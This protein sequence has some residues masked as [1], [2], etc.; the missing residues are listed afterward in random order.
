MRVPILMYHSIDSF[1]KGTPMRGLHVPKYKF[2]IQM[3]ILK[4]LGFQGLSLTQL[5]PYLNG[6]RKGKV[7]GI[8]FDDGYKNN[9]GSA[10]PTLSKLNFS[11]T[12][13]IVSNKIGS[14]NSWDLEK[15][16]PEMALMN[17]REIKTWLDCGMEIGSHT[18]SHKSLKTLDKKDYMIE[19]RNSKR[20]LEQKFNCPIY[21]FCY[22]YGHF[23]EEIVR[24]VSKSNYLSATTV[25]RGIADFSSDKF[26]L[27]R[28]PIW[29]STNIFSFL[30]KFFT[31]YENKK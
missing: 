14:I 19:I 12:C 5:L 3:K 29:R 21:H 11:A 4:I 9:F 25:E 17:S 31:N 2:S 27:P 28:V 1:P 24:Y 8:T 16:L 26:K 30:I 18:C 20:E 7:F 22:P 13:Y 23:T 15:G 6:E 10:L